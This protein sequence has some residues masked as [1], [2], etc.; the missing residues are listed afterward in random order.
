V[1]TEYQA[2]KLGEKDLERMLVELESMSDE[3]AQKSMT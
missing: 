1:I 3:E 2:K